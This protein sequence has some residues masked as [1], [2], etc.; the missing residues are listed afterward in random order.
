MRD[1][2]MGRREALQTRVKAS[3]VNLVTYMLWLQR[4]VVVI[5]VENLNGDVKMDKKN[6]LNLCKMICGILMIIYGIF[7]FVFMLS[8]KER[9]LWF[10]ILKLVYFI[11]VNVLFL[12]NWQ[13]DRKAKNAKSKNNVEE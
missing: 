7:L 11:I 12:Y 10:N 13:K 1:L 3:I 9:P 5:S 8:T 2:A 4:N 6:R